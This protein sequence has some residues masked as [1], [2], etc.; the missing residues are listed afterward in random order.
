MP[1]LNKTT[2][3]GRMAEAGIRYAKDLAEET[4]I[5]FGRL[6]GAV[7]GRDALNLT[8]VYTVARALIRDGE[9]LADAVA[10]ILANPNEGTPDTP[11]QTPPKRT[12]TAPPRRQETRRG[13]AR[14]GV[15]T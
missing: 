2:V 9:T 13:P 4:D 7:G 3:R 15:L 10:D 6:R 1:K 5:P 12:T 14:I 8:D 11:P